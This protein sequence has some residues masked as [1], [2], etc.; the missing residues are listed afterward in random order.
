VHGIGRAETVAVCG[1]DKSSLGQ[2][3]RDYEM[4]V[5]HTIRHVVEEVQSVT[6]L[7]AEGGSVKAEALDRITATGILAATTS[8]K[9]D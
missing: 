8:N 6:I 3:S 1:A 4:V 9:S 7:N 5:P 2:I